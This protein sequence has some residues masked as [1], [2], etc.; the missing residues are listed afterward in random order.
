MIVKSFRASS[1]VRALKKV[2]EE[3]GQEAI[4]LK[5]RQIRLKTGGTAVEITAC[6]EKPTVGVASRVLATNRAGGMKTAEAVAVATEQ[7]KVPP[8]QNRIR[9]FVPE[10]VV[11]DREEASRL[12]G[13]DPMDDVDDRA[14]VVAS[15]ATRQKEEAAAGRPAQDASGRVADKQEPPQATQKIKTTDRAGIVKQA[16]AKL[17][18]AMKPRPQA[19][20][21]AK[22]TN[23]AAAPDAPEKPDDPIA[24][25]PE[26]AITDADATPGE[27]AVA[28]PAASDGS[29]STAVSRPL[30][31][32]DVD[33][34]TI[35]S[36]ISV[37]LMETITERIAGLETRLE[38]LQETGVPTTVTVRNPRREA[39]DDV[40]NRLMTADVPEA[41]VRSFVREL[42]AATEDEADSDLSLIHI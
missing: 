12:L 7:V 35:A 13:H 32:N 29:A 39:I 31:A 1:A 26:T 9:E 14:A 8:T 11:T 10:R 41:F 17:A 40:C 36:A 3:M 23:E 42:S 33:H 21:Q 20:E 19:T 37:K 6:I 22:T 28:Q 24:T 25:S 18:A 4:V 2:R 34:Q 27:T 5:T 38:R 16:A 15:E 30:G